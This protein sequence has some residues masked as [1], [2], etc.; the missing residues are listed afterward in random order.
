KARLPKVG[1]V[2]DSDPYAFG[3]LDPNLVIRAAHLVPDFNSGQTNYLLDTLDETIARSPGETAD[4]QS[5][6]V[7][8]FPDRDM[9]MRYV[10]GGI[11]H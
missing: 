3:F 5:F 11:G 9:I 7:N 2:P 8:I 10:G 6:Y 1:F 4:Y